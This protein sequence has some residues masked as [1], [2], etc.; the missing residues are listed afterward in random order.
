MAE[1]VSASDFVKKHGGS[2]AVLWR[3]LKG[4]VKL[5]WKRDK[6]SGMM[7]V[8]DSA[9]N[10]KRW[11]SRPKRGRPRGIV[12]TP[13]G[14]CSVGEWADRFRVCHRTV[15]RSIWDGTLAVMERDA[16]KQRY[17]IADTA[18]NSRSF[19]NR[20]KGGPKTE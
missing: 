18:Q 8:S 6:E 1:W 14:W 19:Q 4:G 3:N 20:K 11:T 17:L 5:A 10:A 12:A 7:L 16:P 2:V 15:Y 13:A 9:T